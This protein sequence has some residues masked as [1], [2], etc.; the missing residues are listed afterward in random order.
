MSLL[1][2]N[3]GTFVETHRFKSRILAGDYIDDDAMDGTPPPAALVRRN[4]LRRLDR[5]GTRTYSMVNITDS[6]WTRGRYRRNFRQWMNSTLNSQINCVYIT[7]HHA[8][9]Q[10]WGNGDLRLNLRNAGT[11]RFHANGSR[12]SVDSDNARTNCYL[13][14][15]FGCDLCSGA[16]SR[17]YQD[18]F[19]NGA[20]RPI[21]L[22]W[23]STMVVPRRDWPSVNTQ[24]FDFLDGQLAGHRRAP[25]TNKLAWLYQ[26]HPMDV[27]NAWGDAVSQYRTHRRRSLWTRARARHSNGTY[28]RFRFRNGQVVPVEL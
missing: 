18:I 1:L 21:V 23:N 19:S 24:F 12:I 6:T 10:F 3:F 16:N 17:S 28:Y 8:G 9:R 4:G 2:F 14:V 27:I 20:R 11:L 22:G 13:V 25:N 26:N 15:G 7:G 5:A